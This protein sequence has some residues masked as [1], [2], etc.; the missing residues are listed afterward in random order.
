MF[1]NLDAAA[2]DVD[3]IEEPTSDRIERLDRRYAM[4]ALNL[5]PPRVASSPWRWGSRTPTRGSRDPFCP[6]G[7]AWRRR[8]T[9]LLRRTWSSLSTWAADFPQLVPRDSAE[10][11][12]A[13]FCS[14][15]GDVLRPPP[16]GQAIRPQS[17]LPHPDGEPA[18]RP[19]GPVTARANR[20]AGETFWASFA[21]SATRSLNGGIALGPRDRPDCG[22]VT[23]RPAC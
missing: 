19:G 21:L 7:A 2:R 17:R 16:A 3:H 8:A 4:I 22:A 13:D 11:D 9:W 5:S 1:N 15:A 20:P 12:P 6:Q 18:E 10:P 23:I 14:N